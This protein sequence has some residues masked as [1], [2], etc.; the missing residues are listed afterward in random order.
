MQE[1]K[2]Q[3]KLGYYFFTGQNVW[4][5]AR[6]NL[7]KL[8]SLPKHQILTISFYDTEYGGRKK[9]GKKIR[10]KKTCSKRKPFEKMPQKKSMKKLKENHVVP[11]K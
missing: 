4:Y 10:L 11:W 5:S 8:Q 3:I 9:S 2:L 7:F 6:P 1:R